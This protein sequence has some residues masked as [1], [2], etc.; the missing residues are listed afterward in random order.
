[1]DAEIHAMDGNKSVV[2]VLDSGNSSPQ[3]H[4]PVESLLFVVQGLCPKP[5]APHEGAGTFPCSAQNSRYTSKEVL[6]FPLDLFHATVLKGN[7]IAGVDD[8]AVK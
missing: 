5:N 1:M 6:E 2:Q 8:F 3:F 7:H 4:I